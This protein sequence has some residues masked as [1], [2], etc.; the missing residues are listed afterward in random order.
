MSRDISIN[1][2]GLQIKEFKL[3]QMC[4]NPAICMCAKRGSGKSYVCRALLKHHKYI[5]GGVII[6][7]TEKMNP[8][9]GKFF[10]DLY[11]H[12]EY[13]SDLV[14]KILD[15]Q[16]IMIEKCIEKAKQ[17]KKVDPRAF[18]LM[19]D[20][21]ADAKAW[22]REKPILEIFQNGRH[23]QL[24]FIL[25]MQYPLG[26]P[27]NLR[28]NLDYIFLLAEDTYG[29]QKRL[30]DNYAGMFPTFESFRQVFQ[31]L[32]ENYGCMVIINRGNRT[33]LSEKIFFFKAN[34]ESI[35]SF[36]CKQFIE[37]SES[38]YDSKWKFKNKSI[39]IN[40]F[41]GKKK[42]SKILVNKVKSEG[43]H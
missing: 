42:Q 40:N 22:I 7:K 28:C 5:P 3:E 35:E 9:Y 11:I 2:K 38:N 10:P 1:G 4:I 29:I 41:S 18:L 17:G 15:R 39:D 32:T 26:I 25:T 31:Q 6:S 30:Y 24:M 43:E 13:S 20:C 14:Q 21:L 36:G 16:E 33:S 34:N 37:F 8:F 19:D 27:P 23:Y 12:Y